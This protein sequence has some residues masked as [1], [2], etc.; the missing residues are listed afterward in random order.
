MAESKKY[1][2][3]YDSRR[4]RAEEMLETIRTLE[5]RGLEIMNSKS[6]ANIGYY[7]KD[8]SKDY[9]NLVPLINMVLYGTY[10]VVGMG[11]EMYIAMIRNTTEEICISEMMRIDENLEIISKMEPKTKII[12]DIFKLLTHIKAQIRLN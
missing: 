8:P 12:E 9:E 6:I 5:N 11:T 2:Q 4:R 3:E 1:T 7:P 10:N